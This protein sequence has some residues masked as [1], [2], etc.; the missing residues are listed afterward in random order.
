MTMLLSKNLFMQEHLQLYVK[1]SKEHNT[2]FSQNKYYDSAG[3]S[4]QTKIHPGTM[5]R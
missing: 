2:K 5:R 3:Q 1:S 4:F